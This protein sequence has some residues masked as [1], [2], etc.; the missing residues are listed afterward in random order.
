MKNHN[1]T[2][3]ERGGGSLERVFGPCADVEQ[4]IKDLYIVNTVAGWAKG[5]LKILS[6]MAADHKLPQW[7][8][9]EIRRIS[10][11]IETVAMREAARRPNVEGMRRSSV[12][13]ASIE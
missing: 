10:D 13:T 5:R 11:E 8:V 4:R 6:E 1:D 12:S 2:S 7:C 9:N 3:A